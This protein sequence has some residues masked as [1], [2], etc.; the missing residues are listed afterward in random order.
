MCS[1]LYSSILVGVLWFVLGNIKIAF[2]IT[3]VLKY[4]RRIEFPHWPLTMLALKEISRVG[5]TKYIF[6]Y[7][8]I[9]QESYVSKYENW[10]YRIEP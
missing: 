7:E 9:Y 5:I 1:I 2:L 3:P 4:I 10:N 6:Y 8:I